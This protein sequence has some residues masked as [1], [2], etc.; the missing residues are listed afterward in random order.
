MNAER[1]L[2]EIP[3]GGWFKYLDRG[4]AVLCVR[5]LNGSDPHGNLRAV[6]SLEDGFLFHLS[7]D[8][9]VLP[10]RPCDCEVVR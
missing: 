7:A 5:L 8:T 10:A 1:P 4:E 3:T 2:S 6:V 9:P